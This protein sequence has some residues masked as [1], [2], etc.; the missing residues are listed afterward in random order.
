MDQ[1]QYRALIIAE[2]II[3]GLRDGVDESLAV[4]RMFLGQIAKDINDIAADVEDG[5]N[6]PD[7]STTSEMQA[8]EIANLLLD[9]KS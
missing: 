5:L 6:H 7:N 2:R 3:R 8:M 1:R 4:R 9:N